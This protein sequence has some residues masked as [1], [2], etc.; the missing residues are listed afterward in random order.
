MTRDA[1]PQTMVRKVMYEERCTMHEIE[2]SDETH[3]AGLAK[4]GWTAGQW[5]VP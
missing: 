4:Q 5:L 2:T 1:S 3:E